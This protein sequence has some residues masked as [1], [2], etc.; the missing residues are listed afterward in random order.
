[1][2]SSLASGL[3]VLAMYIIKSWWDDKRDA[4]KQAALEKRATEIL[5]SSDGTN[6]V[7]KAVQQAAIEQQLGRLVDSARKV[8]ESFAPENVKTISGVPPLQF[9]VTKV[10]SFPE[11]ETTPP[12]K[13]TTTDV[14]KG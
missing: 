1:M 6:D 7:D 10:E 2:W 3:G 4:R 14:P 12:M 13:P 8:R 11:E 9:D 5:K